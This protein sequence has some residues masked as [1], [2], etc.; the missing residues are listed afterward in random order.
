MGNK[1]M[2]SGEV[3]VKIKPFLR[4]DPEAFFLIFHN[5]TDKDSLKKGLFGPIT[6][7]EFVSFRIVLRETLFRP[8][9]T[10]SLYCHRIRFV[11]GR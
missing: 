7:Q 6:L 4:P 9:S 10:V 11:Y 8:R 2:L 3:V 5:A 1:R